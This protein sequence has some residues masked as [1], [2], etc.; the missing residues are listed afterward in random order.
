MVVELPPRVRTG[1]GVGMS[2]RGDCAV[3]QRVIVN[4][5]TVEVTDHKGV[6]IWHA[7]CFEKRYPRT[8]REWT[9]P[10]VTHANER[11]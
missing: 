6:R 3:C 11:N 9:R 5:I 2:Y 7:D 1:E 4:G 10:S 8:F